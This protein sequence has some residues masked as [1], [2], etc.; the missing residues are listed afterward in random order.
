[1]VIT[2]DFDF[3]TRFPGTQ[4][5]TLVAPFFFFSLSLATAYPGGCS[6]TAYRGR[7]HRSTRR[8]LQ[9]TALAARQCH[10]RAHDTRP[11]TA[12]SSCP[13]PQSCHK[14]P[15]SPRMTSPCPPC[16]AQTAPAHILS[17]ALTRIYAHSTL[18]VLTGSSF[19]QCC[20]SFSTSP[21]PC[22]WG[23]VLSVRETK[24]NAPQTTYHPV[25][26]ACHTV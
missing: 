8:T 11:R 4:V 9:T 3:T 1:M 2:R 19:G 24:R 17:T 5:R 16:P 26:S 12:K 14:T 7:V 21:S 22:T 25:P 20:Q 13:R 23:L 10:A 18:S 6:T 15:A